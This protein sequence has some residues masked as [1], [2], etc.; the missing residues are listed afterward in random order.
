MNLR[1]SQ[2]AVVV[3]TED[4]SLAGDL[5]AVRLE[6][7]PARGLKASKKASVRTTPPCLRVSRWSNTRSNG[8][9]DNTSAHRISGLTES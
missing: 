1:Q 8:R 9:R 6:P 7:E 3:P 4:G 2:F 5:H